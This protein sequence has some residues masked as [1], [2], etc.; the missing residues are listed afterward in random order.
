MRIAFPIFFAILLGSCQS[1]PPQ[2]ERTP[3]ARKN[4]ESNSVVLVEIR[5]ERTFKPV[6]EW[7]TAQTDELRA[8][9]SIWRTIIGGVLGKDE[10]DVYLML[11]DT[12]ALLREGEFIPG[13]RW[14]VHSLKWTDQSSYKYTLQ[15]LR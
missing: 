15:R 5:G 3:C 8:E 6:I 9:T 4:A 1:H 12:E 10:S 2:S 14:K 11:D 7:K 13:T